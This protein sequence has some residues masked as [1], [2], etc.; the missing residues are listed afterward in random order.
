MH[1]HNG[2]NATK[3][4]MN[5]TYPLM[6]YAFA[7]INT[8]LPPRH[9]YRCLCQLTLLNDSRR[10][11]GCTRVSPRSTISY[12]KIF[13]FINF[14][15]SSANETS[16]PMRRDNLRHRNWFCDIQ[17]MKWLLCRLFLSCRNDRVAQVV[18]RFSAFYH[19]HRV[20]CHVRGWP[21]RADEWMNILFEMKWDYGVHSDSTFEHSAMFCLHIGR[22]EPWLDAIVS[23]PM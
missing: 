2:H 12:V 8:Q 3:L 21:G 20:N 14:D 23:F 1:A 7:V 18:T 22:N 9:R 11:S 4:F 16:K 17:N 10:F 6:I 19:V 15:S 5:W 13:G